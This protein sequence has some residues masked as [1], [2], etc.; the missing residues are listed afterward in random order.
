MY[1]GVD[2]K[3][4]LVFCKDQKQWDEFVITQELC[5]RQSKIFTIDVRDNSFILADNING[6][7]STYIKMIPCKN[8]RK[9]FPIGYS[10]MCEKIWLCDKEEF[11]NL[12]WVDKYL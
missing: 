1:L 7:Q 11:E 6:G 10:L 5:V 8:Y 2:M 3:R 4:Y 12:T 9:T